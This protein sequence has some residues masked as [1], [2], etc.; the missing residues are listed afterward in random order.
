MIM[1]LLLKKKGSN[2]YLFW[3][4]NFNTI[5]FSLEKCANY[6]FVLPFDL[7][8]LLDEVVCINMTF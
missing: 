4:V 3:S 6:F 5:V 2:E 8:I 1:R 7:S